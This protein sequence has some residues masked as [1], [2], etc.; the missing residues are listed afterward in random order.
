[1]G[2]FLGALTPRPPD[3]LLGLMAAF[4]ADPRP[5]KLDLGVGVYR[6][7]AGR[8]PVFE[9]VKAAE[10]LLIDAE[11]TKAYE[12][13]RGNAGFCDAVETLVFG[14]AAPA[15]SDGRLVSLTTPGGCGALS[16]AIWFLGRVNSEGR[17]WMSDPTWPNHPHIVASTGR[18]GALYRYLDPRQTGAVDFAAM[19]DSLRE[20]R[21]GDAVIVQGPCHNP[22]GID[23]TEAQW[24]YLGEFCARQ[25]LIPLVDVAYQG[26]GEGLDADM[27]GVRAFLERAPEAL[28]SYSCSKNFGLYRERTG[29]LILQAMAPQEAETAASH[30]AD[31]AR[32]AWSMPPAHGAAIVATIL[33]SEGLTRLWQ[34]ELTA[35]RDR[36][37]ALRHRFAD[38]LVQETGSHALAA[39]ARQKGMFSLLPVTPHAIDRL[40]V[41]F[42]IYMP[43]S[44]RVNMAGLSDERIGQVARLM[45]A[46][47]AS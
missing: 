33:S 25:G 36:M 28:V 26:F 7:A 43:Q 1:M 16:L 11:G 45:A 2:M 14:A 30:L 21:P 35:V 15:R 20:A 13:P 12:G 18:Q 4:Q 39:I 37:Q 9:A 34:D 27:T 17:I 23:L 44:G 32:A 19:M 5:G 38:A 31:I 46:A 3:A 47:T 6:D 10:R 24:T 41:E 22:T 8:T 29:C 40:R 42:G